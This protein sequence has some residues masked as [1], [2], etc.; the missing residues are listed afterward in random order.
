MTNRPTLGSIAR[1]SALGLLASAAMTGL[2]FAEE[3]AAAAAAPVPN[4]GDTAWLLIST[5]LVLMMSIPGLA[6]FYGG[7]VRAKNMLSV[8][9]QVFI[10]GRVLAHVPCGHDAGFDRGDFLERRRRS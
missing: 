8:L 6:L 9:T 4:K 1:A 5:A 3:A 2:A 7:L 10:R